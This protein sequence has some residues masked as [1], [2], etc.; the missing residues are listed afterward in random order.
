M[1]GLFYGIYYLG[2]NAGYKI[3]AFILLMLIA[4][5]FLKTLRTFPYEII[6]LIKVLT[7]KK[8]KRMIE[9]IG[10]LRE[11]RLLKEINK[12]KE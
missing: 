9:R 11:R 6:G 7:S 2:Y 8:P 3:I 4:G 1:A 12:L 5:S 10:Y